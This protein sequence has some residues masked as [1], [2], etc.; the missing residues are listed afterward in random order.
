MFCAGN[1]NENFNANKNII[2]VNNYLDKRNLVQNENFTEEKDS[3]NKSLNL[4]IIE[5]LKNLF[6]NAYKK[7]KLVQAIVNAKVIEFLSDIDLSTKK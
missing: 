7:D 3:N 1:T 2:N 4:N 5:S 6:A